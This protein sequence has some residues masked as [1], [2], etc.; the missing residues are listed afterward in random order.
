MAVVWTNVLPI[1]AMN[2][3][4]KAVPDSYNQTLYTL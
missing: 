4:R 1:F 3:I 2:K